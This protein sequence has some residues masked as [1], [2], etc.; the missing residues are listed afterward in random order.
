M[1]EIIYDYLLINEDEPQ[2][3][4][5]IYKYV[6]EE[7][8]EKVNKKKF[9]TIINLME[10]LYDNVY[11]LKK[12]NQL[13]VVYTNKSLKEIKLDKTESNNIL[14]VCDVQDIIDYMMKNDKFTRKDFTNHHFPLINSTL[15]NYLIYNEEYDTIEK[16]FEMTS[17]N[18][19]IKK[20]KQ[21]NKKIRQK[22][23]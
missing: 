1:E 7:M 16:I 19:N 22:N 14:D 23:K 18:K 10:I 17:S 4:T 3:L 8:I 9:F 12:D 2:S 5:V 6:E 15:L 21:K 11:T 20:N 13:F